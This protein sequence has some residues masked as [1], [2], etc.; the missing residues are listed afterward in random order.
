MYGETNHIITLAKLPILNLLKL[1]K[2]A[3]VKMEKKVAF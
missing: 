1:P 2:G 3:I